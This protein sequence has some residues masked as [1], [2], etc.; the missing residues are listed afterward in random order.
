MLEPRAS[1]AIARLVTSVLSVKPL[2]EGLAVPVRVVPVASDTTDASETRSTRWW[3]GLERLLGRIARQAGVTGLS[4]S[5]NVAVEDL[6]VFERVISDRLALADVANA[7]AALPEELPAQADRV[8]ATTVADGFDAF[9]GKDTI[10]SYD[11]VP[12]NVYSAGPGDEAVVLV[13]ACGMPAALAE[14][15]MRFLARDR[16]VLAW[17]SRGLFGAAEQDG[18]CAVDITAQTADLFAVMDHYAVSSAHVVGLCGGAV[19]ALA[20][21]ADQPARI[22]SLSLWHGAYQFGGGSPR[23]RFQNDLIELMTIAAHSRAAARSVQTAF[24]Q[25]A[26]TTTPAETA[27]F[28]LYP[29]TNPELFYRYCRLNGSLATTDVEQ[30]LTK[31]QQPTLVVT[32]EDDETAHPQGSKQVADG[33][34]NGRLRV[35]AH[36]DHSSLFHADTT[37]MQV[38]VDFI[39]QQGHRPDRGFASI[40]C[41]R[42][43]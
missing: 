12:L 41:P 25:V 26:L 5:R 35:E 38:A 43:V 7:I 30:Y 34:P 31:V 2:V 3:S 19:I 39:G 36:G 1:E 24:C 16:R 4:L 42:F 22:S 29:Y 40:D 28:V 33:L 15:W 23:T 8:I 27:H 20:A 14:A 18:D 21:A 10:V 17:E 9:F 32:S 11:G 13:P 37:L 6:Q